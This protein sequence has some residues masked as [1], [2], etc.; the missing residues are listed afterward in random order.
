MDALSNQSIGQRFY[1]ACVRAA[2]K[3]NDAFK[4]KKFMER[5]LAECMIRSGEKTDS[6]QKNKALL[7]QLYIDAESNYIMAQSQ[8]NIAQA[9][10]DGLECMFKSWQSEN[11]TRRA[12]M[13]LK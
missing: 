11:A 5:T 7:N 12:E 10:A 2:E 13:G 4:L 6:K 3:K 9:E 8:A 1:D